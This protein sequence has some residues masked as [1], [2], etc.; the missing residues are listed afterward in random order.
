MW[1]ALGSPR[2]T[3]FVGW[4]LAGA[5]IVLG[6][7]LSGLADEYPTGPALEGGLFDAALFLISLNI[8]RSAWRGNAAALAFLLGMG[9]AVAGLGLAEHDL[10]RM[11]VGLGVAMPAILG[12]VRATYRARGQM[13]VRPPGQ[14]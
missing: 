2:W 11:I 10:V 3:W 1:T 4:V 13:T 7:V 12:C 5:G 14:I 6:I 9:G 8:L